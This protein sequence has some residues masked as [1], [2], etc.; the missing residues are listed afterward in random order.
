MIVGQRGGDQSVGRSAGTEGSEYLA[1]AAASIV[2]RLNPKGLLY[3]VVDD[4][5]LHK[6]GRHVYGLGWFRDAVGFRDAV[7]STAKR[8]ASRQRQPL[9]GDGT[10]HPYPPYQQNINI[11]P[12]D[13]RQFEFRFPLRHSHFLTVLSVKNPAEDEVKFFLFHHRTVAY[14]LLLPTAGKDGLPRFD[15]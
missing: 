11:L 2:V 3:L 15:L 13:P 12:A 6:R 9:G 8:A 10:G 5:L 7:A 4:T 1:A 14:K